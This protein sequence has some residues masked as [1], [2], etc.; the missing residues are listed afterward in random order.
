MHGHFAWWWRCADGLK[1]FVD[2]LELAVPWFGG[3]GATWSPVAAR[4]NENVAALACGDPGPKAM[5]W[6]PWTAGG[7]WG[8][9]PWP[10]GGL[11]EDRWG[12]AMKPGP[13]VWR[14]WGMGLGSWGKGQAQG[15]GH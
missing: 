10:V 7:L 4:V 11:P 5:A 14:V 3:I 15:L 12:W 1:V 2:E 13:G 8:R 6:Q 9:R